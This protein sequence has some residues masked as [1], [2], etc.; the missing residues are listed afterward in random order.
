MFDLATLSL[1]P[2]VDLSFEVER[3]FPTHKMRG[4]QERHDPGGGA[5]NV[6]RVFVR[7]G[8]NARC[9]YMAGGAG[10]AAL[11]HLLDLHLM[12]RD[13]IA[14]A[15]ETRIS[16]SIFERESGCE[17]RFTTEGPLIAPGEWAACLDRMRTVHCDYLVMSGSLPR[18]VP[19]DFYAQ[20]AAIATANGIK[21]VLDSSGRG[22]AGGLSGPEILLV[23]P[24]LGELTALAGKPLA[25]DADI[26][27]AASRIVQRGAA[28]HVAVTM[29]RD[30]ALLVGRDGHLRLPAL[31]VPVRSAV[32]AGD[33]FLAAMVF[34]LA[35]GR[36]IDAAFRFGA[37]AGAAAVL[38]PGTG[39]ADVEDIRRLAGVEQTFGSG[40]FA[41]HL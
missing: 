21:V 5:I 39:L 1:N 7:L 2:A 26:L 27:D 25:T 33:S 17:F 37:A 31:P 22:L 38:S 34:A 41:S 3:I 11:D 36:A 35:E 32:G 23:K 15:G 40:E 20:V 6:A 10:G 28:R 8:G 9:H 14:I 19:D 30:G 16:T 24:S 12:V 29:G 13:R 4:A 18:G